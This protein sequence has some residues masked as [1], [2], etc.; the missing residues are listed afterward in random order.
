MRVVIVGAGVGGLALARGLV[1]VGHEVEVHE[2]EGGP[3]A[4][5]VGIGLRPNGVAA[6]AALGVDVSGLGRRLDG[7][8]VR[9]SSGRVRHTLD[10]DAIG[11]RFGHAWRAMPRRDLLET[12]ADGLPEG[13]V[14]SGRICTRVR[15]NPDGTVS[16]LFGDGSAATGDV[17]VGADGV[18]SAARR[19]LWDGDPSRPTG[20][21]GW[22]G[23][24]AVP[25]EVASGTVAA[26]VRGRQGECGIMPAGDGL[27]RWWFDVRWRPGL[28]APRSPMSVLRRLF[29]DWDDPW[30]RA[31]L[32]QGDDVEPALFEYV[33]HRV[34]KVWG[35]GGATLLGDAAHPFSSA[36]SPGPDQALEDAWALTEVLGG[37]GAG[38]DPADALR[39]YERDRR[40]R[41]TRAAASGA[42]FLLELAPARALGPE[43]SGALVT[44]RHIDLLE[45][46]SGVLTG[47]RP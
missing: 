36:D 12:I 29:A 18:R 42:E 39:R 4:V 32:D 17:V 27:V 6:L 5:E 33:R 38:D 22:H 11:A 15:E 7:I 24:T 25:G 30:T 43:R 19:D 14:R 9:E 10:T 40:G 45:R 28:R 35:K 20:R 3:P 37:P 44:R 21:A 26:V 41:V 1:G 2:R 16:A 46:T 23:L 47:R 8:E 13:T 31:V 34:P